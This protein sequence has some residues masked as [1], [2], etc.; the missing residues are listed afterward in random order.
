MRIGLCGM[1]RSG[2][3]EGRKILELEYGF[4]TLDTK[5]VLREMAATLTGLRSTDFV[6]QEDKEALFEGVQ[7]RKIMGELGNVAE[8]L[9]GDSYMIERALANPAFYDGK[10]IV[11][12]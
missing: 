11:V 10:R 4:V 12:D 3:T 8:K 1:P 7:R 6:T 2:K 9:W 5:Q